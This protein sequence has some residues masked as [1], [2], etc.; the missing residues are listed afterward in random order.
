MAIQR[1]YYDI[2][3]ISPSATTEQIRTQFRKLAR[4]RHPDRYKGDARAVAEREFQEIAE[5]Y[6]VLVDPAQRERYDQQ[7]D[8]SKREGPAANPKDIARALL[9]K[10]VSLA[11]TGQVLE[12]NQ[13]FLQAVAH[14]Q[15]SAK[16][17]QIYGVFLASQMNR[18]DEGMRHLDQAVKLEP[19]D[20]KILL[21]ASRLFA[22]GKMMTRA[23]RLA[24]QAA[25][26]APGDPVVEA[27][28]QELAVMSGRG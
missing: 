25:Q 14:D 10:A 24:Q 12:A 8:K 7:S 15:Q 4:E 5:A 6:N 1:S 13:H 22:R 9:A 17:H 18:L 2:L 20:Y 23:T 19:N 16:A 27:W 26:L 28:L 11:K 21:D 3:G